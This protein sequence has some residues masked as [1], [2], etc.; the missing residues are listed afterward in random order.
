MQWI[1]RT[2]FAWFFELYLSTNKLQIPFWMIQLTHPA[3]F[4]RIRTGA[5]AQYRKLSSIPNQ[6]QNIVIFFY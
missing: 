2:H 1:S 6:W 3:G 4:E 5:T